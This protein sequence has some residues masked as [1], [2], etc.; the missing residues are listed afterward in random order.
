MRIEQK[1][2]DSWQ[3]HALGF[4]ERQQLRLLASTLRHPQRALE[5]SIREPE[6]CAMIAINFEDF[7]RQMRRSVGLPVWSGPGDR[8]TVDATLLNADRDAQGQAMGLAEESSRECLLVW[9]P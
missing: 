9:R 4:A 3:T 6:I 2:V 1:T 5:P 7:L 8:T